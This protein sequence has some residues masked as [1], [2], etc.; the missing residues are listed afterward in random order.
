MYTDT[1]TFVHILYITYADIVRKK[2]SRRK[3]KIY[4]IVGKHFLCPQ[5]TAI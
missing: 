5:A 3:E 2:G 1:Y 4:C